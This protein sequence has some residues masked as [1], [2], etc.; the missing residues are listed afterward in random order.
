M[1]Q[2]VKPGSN[3]N[4]EPMLMLL[5][6]RP[7]WIAAVSSPGHMDAFI[8]A[9]NWALKI[10]KPFWHGGFKTTMDLTNE[11]AVELIT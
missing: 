7:V 5:R 2:M 1:I 3:R 9:E 6:K 4:D 8:A 11:A 10:H